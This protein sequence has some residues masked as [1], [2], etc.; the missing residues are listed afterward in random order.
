MVVFQALTWETEDDKM[1]KHLS[2]Y[3]G[4]TQDGKS[5]C[6]TTEFKPYFFINSHGKI[7][8]HGRLY[9]MIKY[10]NYVLTLILNMS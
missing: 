4:K 10:V 1:K 8:I 6:L 3:F 2:T 5:V 9:G 7:R